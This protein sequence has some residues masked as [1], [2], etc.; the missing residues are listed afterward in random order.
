[1]LVLAALAAGASVVLAAIIVA[2]LA[3]LGAIGF[4]FGLGRTMSR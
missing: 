4:R 2:V 1:V 3:I